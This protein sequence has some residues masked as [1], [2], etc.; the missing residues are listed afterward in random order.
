MSHLNINNYLYISVGEFSVYYTLRNIRKET[1]YDARDEYGR[2]FSYS[3]ENDYYLFNLST[4][5]NEAI[6]KAKIYASENN[7]QL[8]KVNDSLIVVGKIGDAK[9]KRESKYGVSGGFIEKKKPDEPIVWTIPKRSEEE[10]ALEKQKQLEYDL[11]IANEKK[12]RVKYF[13]DPDWKIIRR[14][15]YHSI[16]YKNN[17]DWN[18]NLHTYKQYSLEWRKEAR[19][20]FNIAS[21]FIKDMLFNIDNK[22]FFSPRQLEIVL[23]IY[24]KQ[25]GRKGSKAYQKEFDRLITKF[26]ENNV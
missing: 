9:Q 21:G 22:F 11:K 4:D 24:C 23:D 3:K 12:A 26:G 7:L 17:N 14:Y 1:C 25:F 16:I 18:W 19:E 13:S 20:I 5:K 6:K 2:V 15:F 8:K 10:K